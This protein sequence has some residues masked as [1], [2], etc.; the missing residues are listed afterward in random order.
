MTAIGQIL[1]I[2]RDG[3]GAAMISGR[4]LYDFVLDG[5]KIRP[6]LEALRRALYDEFGMVLVTYSLA[7]GVNWF[8]S[9]IANEADRRFLCL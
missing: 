9:W 6:L 3:R 4:S 8:E 7:N 2:H 5:G 1:D